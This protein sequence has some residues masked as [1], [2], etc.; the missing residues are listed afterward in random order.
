MNDLGR[1][2][3]TIVHARDATVRTKKRICQDQD[4]IHDDITSTHEL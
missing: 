1:D 2:D 3:N 4:C